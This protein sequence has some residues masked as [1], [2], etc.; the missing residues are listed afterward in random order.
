ML[1]TLAELVE[2]GRL[3]DGM[4]PEEAQQRAVEGRS[5]RAC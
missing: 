2:L 4:T 5:R 1:E 3:P